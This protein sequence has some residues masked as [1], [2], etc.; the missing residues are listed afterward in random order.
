MHFSTITSALLLGLMATTPAI[1]KPVGFHALAARAEGLYERAVEHSLISR[2]HKGR[3]GGNA[4]QTANGQAQPDI[5]ATIACALT[6]NEKRH[7]KG[8]ANAA[9]AAKNCDGQQ[10]NAK[11]NKNAKR[12]PHHKGRKGANAQ[13]QSTGQAQQNQQSAAANAAATGATKCKRHH[14]GKGG[15]NNAAAAANCE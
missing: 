7:H 10:A 2:H 8:A 6:G 13:A 12:S 15:A 14:K 1:A 5:A 9:G 4:G 11:T 3:N